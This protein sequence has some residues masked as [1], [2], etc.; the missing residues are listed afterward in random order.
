MAPRGAC[1]QGLSKHGPAATRCGPEFLVKAHGARVPVEH[2]PL[3]APAAA[4]TRLPLDGLQQST[5]DARSAKRRTNKK[6]LQIYP[7]LA[8]K[9]RIVEKIKSEACHLCI[10]LSQQHPGIWL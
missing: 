6:V 4:I 3:E 10:D 7:G 5:A 2:R 9:G 1:L 8:Q